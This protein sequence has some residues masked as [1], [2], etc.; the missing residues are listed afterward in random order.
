MKDGTYS[1]SLKWNSNHYSVCTL[2]KFCGSIENRTR[3]PFI[4]R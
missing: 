4:T 3:D 1:Y 2:E